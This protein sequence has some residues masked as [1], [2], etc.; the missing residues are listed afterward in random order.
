MAEKIARD[1]V[2]ADPTI[3]GLLILDRRHGYDVLAVARSPTLPPEAHASPALVKKF[4][5]A[6]T[7][8]WG[9]AEQAA[10]LM[11][12]REFIVGAFKE[13]MVLLVDLREYDMLLAMRLARSSNAEH[14]YLKIVD[15]LGTG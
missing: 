15:L 1:V 7:V 4:A 14:L 13:Q 9:A 8:V 11:G 5:I 12:G 6:A 3:F 2:N 10:Q